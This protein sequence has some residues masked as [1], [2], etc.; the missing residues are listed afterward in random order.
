MKSHEE[1]DLDL[2]NQNKHNSMADKEKELFRE[3]Y[4]DKSYCLHWQNGVC[5]KKWKKHLGD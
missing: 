2:D 5:L 3:F 4:C 1:H